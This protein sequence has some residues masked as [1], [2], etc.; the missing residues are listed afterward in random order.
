MGAI[1]VD[2]VLLI[3]CLHIFYPGFRL[4]MDSVDTRCPSPSAEPEVLRSL[5]RCG[6]ALIND[7]HLE[8]GIPMG[9]ST[10]VY[11]V[12]EKETG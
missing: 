10:N 11:V 9:E 4:L 12:S 6:G 1:L 5:E 2:S 8:Q 3:F 7:E